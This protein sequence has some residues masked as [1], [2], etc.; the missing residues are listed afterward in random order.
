M[1]DQAKAYKTQI[2]MGLSKVRQAID[3]A[4]FEI[5]RHLEQAARAITQRGAGENAADIFPFLT[6]MLDNGLPGSQG[7]AQVYKAV[8]ARKSWMKEVLGEQ[9]VDPL[10]LTEAAKRFAPEGY[11]TWQPEEGKMLFTAQTLPEHAINRAARRILGENGGGFDHSMFTDAIKTELRETLAVGREKYQLVI[12]EELAS[13]LN[14]LTDE[15]VNG[16]IE[17]IAEAPV[18]WWKR[19]ILINPRRVLTYNIN[20]LSGDL[21]AVIAGNPRAIKKLPQ[22]IRELTNVMIRGKA[23]TQRYREAVERGVFDSGLSVQEIPDINDMAEFEHLTSPLSWKRPD[24]KVLRGVLKLWKG[25]QKFTKWRENWMRYAAYL[26]YVERLEGGES[27]E[28]IGYGASRKVLIDNVTDTKDKA[29]LMARDLVG[30]YGDVSYYGQGLRR[31]VIPFYSWMEI[32]TKRYWRLWGNA[33]KQGTG[34]GLRTAGLSGA[35]LGARVT[36]YLTL[37]M[38]VLYGLVNVWNNLLFGDEEDELDELERTR[39]HLNLGRDDDGTIRTLRFQGALSDFLAWIGFDHARGVL[40]QVDQGKAS[41]WDVVTAMAKAPVNKVVSGLTPVISMPVELASRKSFWPDVFE[42]R[43]IRDRGNH[44]FRLFSLDNEYDAITGRPMK[45]DYATTLIASPIKGRDVG[46]IAYNKFRGIAYDWLEKERGSSGG[47]GFST[48]RSDALY[49]WRKA[50]RYGDKEAE[51]KYLAELKRLG[52]DAAYMRGAIKRAH[53]IGPIPIKDRARFF[54]GL[55]EK[56]RETYRKAIDWYQET[57]T[58]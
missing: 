18:R 57:F 54:G 20:N 16:L 11:V 7:A 28:S 40:A 43:S 45:N 41:Y 14:S 5:P 2:A 29:A 24:K 12:P 33:F 50:R 46:E 47:G 30:D 38:F 34:K 21:D 19:W 48:P 51:A 25:L 15:H 32:N 22:A 10:N 58:Q 3:D 52:A 26:D 53:P 17:E 39:L 27:V 55:S 8:T 6:W 13:T 23:P 44:F 37:R 1:N 49:N 42:P 35:V 9:Y 56:D 31:K 36:G 4:E